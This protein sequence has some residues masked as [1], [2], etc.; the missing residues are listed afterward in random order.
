MEIKVSEN[1]GEY[2]LEIFGWLDTITSPELGKTLSEIKQAKSI[3][4][5]FLN[6]EYMSSAGLRQ[7][8]AGFKQA[9]EINVEY[10][11]INVSNEILSIFQLTGIDKKISI[12]GK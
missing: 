10:K 11:I 2:L 12:T 8:V 7:I 4:I 9:K 3:T 5:D 1:S 6:V